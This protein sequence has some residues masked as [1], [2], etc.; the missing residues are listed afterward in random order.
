MVALIIAGL[1][2]GC[3]HI[4]FG[5]ELKSTDKFRIK[6]LPDSETVTKARWNVD[7]V[8]VKGDKTC[9]HEWQTEFE[10]QKYQDAP[11][12][13]KSILNPNNE[14]VVQELCLKCG[15]ERIKSEV[16]TTERKRYRLR[17]IQ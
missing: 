9:L 15:R 5:Q 3:V 10:S 12:S 14:R 17:I 13:L 7:T 8:L 16:I 2:V 4:C 11:D 6:V 1:M